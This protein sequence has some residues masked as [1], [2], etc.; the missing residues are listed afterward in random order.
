MCYVITS[1]IILFQTKR[2]HLILVCE[3]YQDAGAVRQILT[4]FKKT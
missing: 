4:H 1:H 2:Q 3:N